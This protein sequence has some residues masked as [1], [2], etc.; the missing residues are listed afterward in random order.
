MR[1]VVPVVMLV[2]ASAGLAVAQS[3]ESG[4]VLHEYVAPPAS[5]SAPSASG[6]ARPNKTIGS[7]PAAGK[8][9]AAVRT[10]DKVVPEPSAEEPGKPG[11]SEPVHGTR[12]FGADRDTSMRPDYA[13][14]SDSTLRYV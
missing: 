10:N 8:N 9:P 11:E 5:A 13:T 6:E 1:R 4:P 12:D 14:G 3:T 2:A 7:A